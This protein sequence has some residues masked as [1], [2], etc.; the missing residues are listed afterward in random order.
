M[1]NKTDILFSKLITKHK[2]RYP[3]RKWNRLDDTKCNSRVIS[4]LSKNITLHIKN[5][6]DEAE[7]KK[8]QFVSFTYKLKMNKDS[9]E[10]KRKSK[11]YNLEMILAITSQLSRSAS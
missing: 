6:Y 10:V 9:R 7:L 5:I 11:H 8:C 3:F 2:N 1:E 4:N